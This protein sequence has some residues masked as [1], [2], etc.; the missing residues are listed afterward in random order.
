MNVLLDTKILLWWLADD[1]ALPPRARDAIAD[2]DTSAV[3]SAAT[4]WEIAIKKAAGRL[5]APDDLLAVLADGAF[6]SLAIT[7]GHAIAAAR[8]PSHHADPFDRMLIAQAR[9][10]QLQI[11]T[12]DR[13]FGDYDVGLLAHG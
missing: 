9:A 11:A 12:V 6:D 1:P 4:M 2:P 10:E 8:L 3:I 5:D 13:R 7:A